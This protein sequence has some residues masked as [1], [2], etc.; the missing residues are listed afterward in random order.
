MKSH[1]LKHVDIL[2]AREA[3]ING[4]NVI[5]FF[6]EKYP[7][8]NLQDIIEIS[9]DL[10]AGS[11]IDYMEKNFQKHSK[12]QAEMSSILQHYTDQAE[13]VLDIGTGEMTTLTGLLN[14]M[15]IVPKKVIAFDISYS[16]IFVGLD[17]INKNL[18]A[19]ID[20]STFVG[21]MKAIPLPS[22]SIDV[23]TSSHALEPSGLELT[24]LLKELF[25][26]VKD[27]LVL[28]E[29]YY[30]ICSEEGKKRM[31]H[32]GYIKN[33]GGVV[34][35]LGGVVVDKIIIKNSMNKLNPTACFVIEPPKSGSD[36]NIY[37]RDTSLSY[38][39]PGTDLPLSLMDSF[40]FSENTGLSFPII[41]GIPVL[42]EKSAILSTSLV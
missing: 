4:K 18:N 7:N 16:R 36:T 33:I 9:Y 34:D 20:L 15:K 40:Y 3:Y 38:T 19:R 28:F 26:V 37:S 42:K 31:D 27:K 2:G 8:A 25:R 10:Q 30:E 41:K 17:Y 23:I 1:K 24:A 39:V 6:K 14:G 29:P 5:R 11:Y 22:N 35:S 12:L 32:H 13:A 21:D